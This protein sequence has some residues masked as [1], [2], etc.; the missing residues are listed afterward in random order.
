MALI[1]C[2]E[3]SNEVSDKA[4][5]CPKCGLPLT[6]D[7]K[8]EAKLKA[9][10]KAQAALKSERASSAAATP[11]KKKRL[12]PAI[13]VGFV[14]VVAIGSMLGK[15]ESKATRTATDQSPSAV[16]SSP[17]GTDPRAAL[18]AKID[19]GVFQPYT[20]DQFPKLFQKYGSRM[21]EIQEA[22]EVA[23]F[24][25]TLSGKCDRVEVAEVSSKGTKDNAVFFVD[26][27]NGERFLMSETDLKKKAPPKAQSE[28]SVN[29]SEAHL[30][31]QQAIRNRAQ[32]PS[33]VDFSILGV[34]IA[35][36]KTTGNLRVALD[37]EAKN[38]FGNTLPYRGTCIFD[39][40]GNMEVSIAKR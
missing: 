22:R 20:K 24:T 4:K 29:Q 23:A 27:R 13:V 35:K 25:A 17:N 14:A 34:D 33:S 38:G 12:W 6:W 32:Y 19:D 18:R 39:P 16:D 9:K 15:N 28:K 26:C 37:F 3:C 31:C 21:K 8:L 10:E 1:N 11:A 5:A 30:A 2:P 40:D 7:K 36:G